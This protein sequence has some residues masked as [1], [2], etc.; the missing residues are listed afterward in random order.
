MNNILSEMKASLV[1]YAEIISNITD[2][3]VSI[4]DNEMIRVLYVGGDWRDDVGENCSLRTGNRAVTDHAGAGR[5][6]R[7][8][9][10][11]LPEQMQRKSRDVDADHR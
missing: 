1:R 5:P 2:S 6:S 8:Q 4:I 7:L 3:A 11:Y 9:K 10:M